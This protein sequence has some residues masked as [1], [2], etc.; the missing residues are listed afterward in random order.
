MIEAKASCEASAGGGRSEAEL[1]VGG[2][3]LLDL[4][5]GV[6]RSEPVFGFLAG[7][8][9]GRPLEFI[10]PLGESVLTLAIGVARR[11]L[12]KRE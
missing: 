10:I 4:M 12:R 9:W 8:L 1:E 11:P 6:D 7:I 3:A 5:D 2:D